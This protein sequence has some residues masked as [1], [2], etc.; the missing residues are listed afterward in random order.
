MHRNWSATRHLWSGTLVIAMCIV[1]LGLWASFARISGAVVAPGVVEVELRRQMV[2]HPEGGVVAEILA[3]NGQMLPAA[4][5]LVRLD[6]TEIVAELAIVSRAH[7]EATARLARLQAELRQDKTLV[8]DAELVARAAVDSKLAQSLAEESGLF[9]A[10]QAVLA[11]TDAQWAARI[12]QTEAAVV[13]ID[14]QLA[15]ARSLLAI[16]EDD[17]ATQQELFA[18]GLV[19]RATV[20]A[21]QRETVDLA[22]KVGAFEAQIAEAKS[23]VAGFELERIGVGVKATE[24]VQGEMRQIAPELADL[25]DQLRVLEVRRERLTLRAPMAGI[26]HDLQV[27]TLGSVIPAGGTVASIVPGASGLVL[28]MRVNPAEIDRVWVGQQATV[29]FP[30]LNARVTP[31]VEG[32]VAEIA[33]DIATDEISGETYYAVRIDLADST[34]EVTPLDRLIPGMPAEAHLEAEAR[35]VLSYLLKPAADHFAR[36]MKER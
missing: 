12:E 10:R 17:L 1:G 30:A 36:A 23:T 7:D 29:R 22:G 4:A 21:L 24:S 6:G 32:V 15:A 20:T 35:T 25:A 11:Q 33:A 9:V 31:D 13:G 5:P 3:R 28:S 2:Q 27:A 19:K 18:Q 26:V 34:A 16:A 8:F 14:R